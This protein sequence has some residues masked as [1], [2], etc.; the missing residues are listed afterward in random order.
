MLLYGGTLP[1]KIPPASICSKPAEWR[2]AKKADLKGRSR[3]IS[4][5]VMINK[6]LSG[7]SKMFQVYI[8]YL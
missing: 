1:N 6:G 2:N 4:P 7:I 5:V 3:V 8:I